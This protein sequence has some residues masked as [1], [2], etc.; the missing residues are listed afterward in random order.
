MYAPLCSQVTH[1]YLCRYV[2]T[3][4]PAVWFPLLPLSFVVGYQADMA[5]GNK[6]DRVIAEADRIV[7]KEQHLLEMPGPALSVSLIDQERKKSKA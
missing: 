3:K 2:K 6:M 1:Y 7:A 4:H 5:W